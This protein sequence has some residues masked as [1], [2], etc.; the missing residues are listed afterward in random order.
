MYSEE[1]V[2]EDVEFAKNNGAKY[3]CV[4]I[5]WGDAISENVSEEQKNIADFLVNS[6]VDL[7]IGAHPSV[8][9]PMEIRQMMMAKMYLLHI[10]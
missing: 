3:I 2:E 9:Q 7:I 10:Q 5:H 6:D 4:L 8:V 1:K